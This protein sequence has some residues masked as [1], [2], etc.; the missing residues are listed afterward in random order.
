VSCGKALTPTLSPQGG[1]G[2][3][4]RQREGERPRPFVV[5]IDGPAASGKGT[6][7]R[8][9]AD[10]FG[11]AHLDTGALYRATALLVL[12][13][14]G[15]PADPAVAEAAAR[16]LDTRLLADPRLRGDKVASAASVVAAIVEVRRV[17]LAWQRDF[18]AHPPPPGRGAVLDGRDIGTVVCPEAD[19]KLFVTASAET[20]A[21]RRVKELREQGATAIYENVLQDLKQRDARD[22][23]RPA[24][25]LA[26]ASD[27]EI[28]DSTTLDADAV[29]ERASNLVARTLKE[30]EWQQ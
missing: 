14:A 4:P 6:L 30:K 21:S 23:G 8:R 28:I 12:D 5:A 20:R 11:L 9:L 13:E 1:T 18:A 10:H 17:L 2:R 24:A 7:A 26:A 19:V 29:F 25:P 22:S 3:D 15:D 16:R 27:A